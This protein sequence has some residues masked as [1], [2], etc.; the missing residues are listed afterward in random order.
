MLV[1]AGST[2]VGSVMWVDVRPSA[3]AAVFILA[4][5]AVD[6]A[7]V[8]VGEHRRHVGSGVDQKTFE[9]LELRE[10]FAGRDGDFGLL[11]RLSGLIGGE[12]VGGDGDRRPVGARCQVVVRRTT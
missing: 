6:A 12:C 10:R 9:C 5:K 7:G 11:A 3:V 8:P 2:P 1:V 4:T